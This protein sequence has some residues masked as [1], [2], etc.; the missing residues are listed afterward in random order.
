MIGSDFFVENLNTA[1]ECEIDSK[2]MKAH[3]ARITIPKT[4][5]AGFLPGANA[6]RSFSNPP[7]CTATAAKHTATPAKSSTAHTI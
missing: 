2:P 1:A 3:G 7:L 5:V 4:Y 6:G